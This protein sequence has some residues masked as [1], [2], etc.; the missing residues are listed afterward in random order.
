MISAVRLLAELGQ[1]SL[2]APEDRQQPSQHVHLHGE[3]LVDLPPRETLEQ[4]VARKERELGERS[5]HGR[6]K[7]VDRDE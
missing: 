4:W 1:V 7:L 2:K 5:A 6:L 3:T